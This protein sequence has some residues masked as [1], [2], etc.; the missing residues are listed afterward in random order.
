M[1]KQKLKDLKKEEDEYETAV[2]E[3]KKGKEYDVNVSRF[4]SDLIKAEKALGKG[5]E[6]FVSVSTD[7]W[8]VIGKPEVK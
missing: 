3:N 6:V 8:Q 7:Y 1:T 2:V 5:E 4:A